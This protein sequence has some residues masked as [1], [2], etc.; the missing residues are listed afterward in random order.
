MIS[1]KSDSVL[2]DSIDGISVVVVVVSLSSKFTKIISIDSIW[3]WDSFSNSF[4]ILVKVVSVMSAV[5]ISKIII[6]DTF[7]VI[8]SDSNKS[9]C[10]I[11]DAAV[12]F[13]A[14]AKTVMIKS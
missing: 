6:N 7:T 12:V 14:A 3:I 8:N 1:F 2:S 5:F 9:N 10:V 13:N 4:C 11:S